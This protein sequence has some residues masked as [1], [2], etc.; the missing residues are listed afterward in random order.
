MI[1]ADLMEALLAAG[2][3]L[4]TGLFALFGWLARDKVKQDFL[5][6]ILSKVVQGARVVVLDV[7]QPYVDNLKDSNKDGKF[8]PAEMKR[9]YEAAMFRLKSY[10]GLKG[11]EALTKDLGSPE[12]VEEFLASHIEAAVAETKLIEKK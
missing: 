9:A 4:L 12:A 8:G 11:I 2:G 3:A 10:V 5:K 7:K 1:E 6:M